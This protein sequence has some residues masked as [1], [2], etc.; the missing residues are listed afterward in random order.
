[1]RK[2]QPAGGLKGSLHLQL[3]SL[4]STHH[5]L[6]LQTVGSSKRL[7]RGRPNWEHL[8]STRLTKLWSH[9]FP[10]CFKILVLL[11]G[12][13]AKEKAPRSLLFNILILVYCQYWWKIDR[14][15]RRRGEKKGKVR[16]AERGR[17]Q[18]DGR[19]KF[20]YESREKT[21]L[22]SVLI[23]LNQRKTSIIIFFARA[24][25]FWRVL[26]YKHAPSRILIVKCKKD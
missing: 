25:F 17:R 1:M 22:Q 16:E 8:I 14:P 10:F 3:S 2:R 13:K 24:L 11:P 7:Q 12:V 9:F 19:T 6:N 18:T 23:K 21:S 26:D 4:N 15:I 20:L 5:Y